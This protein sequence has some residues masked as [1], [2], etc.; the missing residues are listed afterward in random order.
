MHENGLQSNGQT[1]GGEGGLQLHGDHKG[2]D[3]KLATTAIKHRWD[4]PDVIKRR[5][6]AQVGRA[7]RCGKGETDPRALS[8]LGRVL[9]TAEAQNQSDEHVLIKNDPPPA[10]QHQH[11]HVHYHKPEMPE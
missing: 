4:I 2:N 3:R 9:Q 5:L 8:Q 1:I 6:I 10:Q 7:L 11:V